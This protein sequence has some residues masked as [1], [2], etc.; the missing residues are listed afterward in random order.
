MK[1][2]VCFLVINCAKLGLGGVLPMDN[3]MKNP[4]DPV[5]L[6]NPLPT[7]HDFNT[8]TETR[9]PPNKKA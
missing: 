1:G 4:E 6:E 8:F 3:P 2:L 5:K 9:H 7:G